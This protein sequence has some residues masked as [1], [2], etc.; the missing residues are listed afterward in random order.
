LADGLWHVDATLDL[1]PIGRRMVIVRMGD[2]SLAVHS[3]VC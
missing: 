1:L 2:G 3:A